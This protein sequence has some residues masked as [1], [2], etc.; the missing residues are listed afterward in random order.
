V[1]IYKLLAGVAI[2]AALFVGGPYLAAHYGFLAPLADKAAFVLVVTTSF[3]I[4]KSLLGG[5]IAGEFAFHK[6]GYDNCVMTFGAVLTALA[7]QLASQTDVFPGL[8][9]V[10]LLQDIP[11]IGSTPA[12]RRSV[13]L[14]VF[15]LVALAATL[16][17]GAVSAAINNESA[18]GPHF[19][20]LMN[21]GIG[22]FLLGLYVLLLITKG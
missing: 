17:T 16:L 3:L 7:L 12:I 6:F 18:K 2:T 4:V 22:L 5:V 1:H 20:A 21:T 14:L 19:L 9:S 15:L 10:A 8:S 11:V 13:Q